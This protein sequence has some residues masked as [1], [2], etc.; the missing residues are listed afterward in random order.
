M[1]TGAL[2]HLDSWTSLFYQTQ[3]FQKTR[4]LFLFQTYRVNNYFLHASGHAD[5]I[6]T[7]FLFVFC[8]D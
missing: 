3:M 4:G 2:L 5:Y 1:L 6:F 7:A 8:P